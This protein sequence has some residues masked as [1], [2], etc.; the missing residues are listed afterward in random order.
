MQQASESRTALSRG[1]VR[2]CSTLPPDSSRPAGGR[3]ELSRVVSRIRPGQGRESVLR[4]AQSA[5]LVA[6]APPRRD[7][8]APRDQGRLALVC[9]KLLPP[10][11]PGGATRAG[12][13]LVDDAP[14]LPLYRAGRR[15]VSP[16]S[17]AD[18]LATCGGSAFP[19]PLSRRRTAWITPKNSEGGR[20]LAV[21]RWP[22]K[23]AP[24]RFGSAIGFRARF[25]RCSIVGIGSAMR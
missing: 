16:G 11:S 23:L 22:Q 4:P 6:R 13:R 12:H 10:L 7:D 15:R 1:C 18:D 14:G 9:T 2:T 24:L 3:S 8:L 5:R 25:G 20:R 19:S 21:P 17:V